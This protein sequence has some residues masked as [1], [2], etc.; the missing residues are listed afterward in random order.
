MGAWTAKVCI[1]NLARSSLARRLLRV[2][3]MRQMTMAPISRNGKSIHIHKRACGAT[4]SLVV[5]GLGL[6]V[7]GWPAVVASGISCGVEGG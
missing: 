3:L 5:A 2:T 1:S 4:K 7:V 6:A